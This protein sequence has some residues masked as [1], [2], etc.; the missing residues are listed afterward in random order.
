MHA[1]EVS[2]IGEFRG[3]GQGLAVISTFEEIDRE[4]YQE[5]D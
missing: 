1:G 3:I 2:S 4:F 5:I